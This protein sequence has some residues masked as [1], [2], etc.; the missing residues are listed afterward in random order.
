MTQ[1]E[2]HDD[3][4]EITGLSVLLLNEPNPFEFEI[5]CRGKSLRAVICSAD[6][7]T[8]HA[9]LFDEAISPAYP[10]PDSMSG[11]RSSTDA[12]LCSIELAMTYAGV[13]KAPWVV[14]K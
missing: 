6:E 9:S 3:T 14:E 5:K 13:E 4:L 11:F 7:E 8:W 12:T 2:T 1:Q 10:L